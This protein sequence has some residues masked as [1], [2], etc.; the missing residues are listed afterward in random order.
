MTNCLDLKF[1]K[2]LFI[3]FYEEIAGDEL[4]K[5]LQIKQKIPRR[6]ALTS[7]EDKVL[8]ILTEKG[9][10][11]K[12]ASFIA[13]EMIP[14][15]VEDEDE[16]EVVVDGE[17]DEGDVHIKPMPRKSAPLVMIHTPFSLDLLCLFYISIDIGVPVLFQL[18]LVKSYLSSGFSAVALALGL[19][20][21]FP[22]TYLLIRS[23]DLLHKPKNK[24]ELTCFLIGCNAKFQLSSIN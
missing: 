12:D 11:D 14:D 20:Y 17:I 7:L 19:G 3:C 22:F 10:V 4:M 16:D 5:V 6:K 8:T 1:E 2:V 21:N 13:T 24:V 23:M 18:L 9:Y 15:I